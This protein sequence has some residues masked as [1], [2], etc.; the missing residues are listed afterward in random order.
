MRCE[1]GGKTM[2]EEIKMLTIEQRKRLDELELLDDMG[3]LTEAQ[4]NERADLQRA[5]REYLN[6]CQRAM[7]AAIMAG[8][9]AEAALRS[10]I[11][12]RGADPDTF[13]S[14]ARKALEAIK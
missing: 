4:E 5:T 9:D 12:T 1:K 11:A 13:K 8:V 7:H 10:A 3:N 14:D 6:S 2:G